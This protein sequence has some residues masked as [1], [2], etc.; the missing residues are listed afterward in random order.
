MA[1]AGPGGGGTA[2]VMGGICCA[3]SVS[4]AS[5]DSAGSRVSL[6]MGVLVLF[7]SGMWWEGCKEGKV[8]VQKAGCAATK[9]VTRSWR[10]SQ[11]KARNSTHLWSWRRSVLAVGWLAGPVRGRRLLTGLLGWGLSRRRPLGRLL[12]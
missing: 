8:Q 4:V 7:G 3:P 10:E 2:W 9:E 11:R 12:R 1:M 6:M 5:V